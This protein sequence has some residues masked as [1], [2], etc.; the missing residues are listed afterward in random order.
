MMSNDPDR[1]STR[2]LRNEVKSLRAGVEQLTREKGDMQLIAGRWQWL[3]QRAMK[4][5]NSIDDVFEYAYKK[6]T[7][8]GL[9]DRIQTELKVLCADVS[10]VRKSPTEEIENRG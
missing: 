1:M 2:E 10:K 9:K 3:F 4:T 6:Y 5:I 8:D 7:S